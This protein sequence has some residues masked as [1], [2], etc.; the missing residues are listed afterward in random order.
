MF[1]DEM[2]LD[3]EVYLKILSN[4]LGDVPKE[5]ELLRIAVSSVDLKSVQRISHRLKGTAG[6]LRL[7]DIVPVT[8]ELNDLSKEG[9]HIERYPLLLDQIEAGF[10]AYQQALD[11]A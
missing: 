5:I 8:K 2:G 9:S 1:C 3:K 6:N 11:H 10:K 7:N 4:A